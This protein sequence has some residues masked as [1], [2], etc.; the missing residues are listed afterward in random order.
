[1]PGKEKAVPVATKIGPGEAL[2]WKCDAAAIILR[3]LVG[4]FFLFN[5]LHLFS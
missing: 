5:R 4:F 1:M 2:H 3:H